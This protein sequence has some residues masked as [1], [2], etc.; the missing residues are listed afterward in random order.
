MSICAYSKRLSSPFQGLVHI[1]SEPRVRA[2]SLNAKDWELQFLVESMRDNVP[3]RRYARVAGWIKS[4]GLMPFP[5]PP[6]IDAKQLEP[7]LQRL[8]AAL[9][10]QLIPLAM[11]DKFELWLLEEQSLQPLALLKTCHHLDEITPAPKRPRWQAVAANQL[12]IEN[13]QTEQQQ[14]LPPISA[15]VQGW[16][17]KCAGQ[18]PKACW[19]QRQAD[20]SGQSL[21]G[22]RQLSTNAFPEL[23]LREDW[24]DTD[25][26]SLCQRYLNRLAPRLLTLQ[27]LSRTC[28]LRLEN[29]SKDYALEV[30][31]NYHLFPEVVD[32]DGI[33]ALLVEAQLRRAHSAI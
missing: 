25:A 6:E 11:E 7:A 26:T 23:M 13:T 8:S 1:I 2:L 21:T 24:Q 30:E 9:E 19:F 31:A 28:R 20:G 10:N 14:G 18:N 12:K 4:E 5:V 3:L 22:D 33:N 32:K 15:R 29:A 17:R 27:K 16:V